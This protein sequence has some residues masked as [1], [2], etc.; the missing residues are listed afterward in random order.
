MHTAWHTVVTKYTL[1]ILKHS[2]ITRRL[3]D[4]TL[5]LGAIDLS[6]GASDFSERETDT[7][8][9]R[10]RQRQR[11]RE[12]ERQRKR[13]RERERGEGGRAADP[14]YISRDAQQEGEPR[15]APPRGPRRR[16]PPQEAG[17]ARR[18]QVLR[19]GSGVLFRGAAQG[20]ARG[21]LGS[22]G[23]QSRR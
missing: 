19:L 11:D 21:A 16:C 18:L 23:G 8:R 9:E 12:T 22:L 4:L 7:E 6:L 10:Q 20:L 14:D 5:S 13:E 2:L 17:G 3:K 15:P 1:R